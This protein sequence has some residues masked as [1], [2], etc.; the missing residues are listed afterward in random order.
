M[1]F[2]LSFGHYPNKCGTL[3]WASAQLCPSILGSFSGN[4]DWNKQTYSYLNS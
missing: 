3:E 4:A 1:P 2:P